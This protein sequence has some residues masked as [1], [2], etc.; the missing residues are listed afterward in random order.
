MQPILH[1]YKLRLTNLSQGNRSL[2]LVRLSARRD[3]D[4]TSLSF[5]NKE[6]AEQILEKILAGRD[7]KLIQKLS[8]RDE[9]VNLLDRRLNS[10]YRSVTS[11]YEESGTYDLY[12]GYPFVEGKFLDGSS[13]RCPVMLFPVKLIRNFQGSPRWRLE[14]QEEEEV[15]LNKTFFL[16]FEKF[17]QVRF[18]AEFW[19]AEIP[20]FK[21]LQEYLN[22]FYAFLKE[23][24]V[25]VNFNSDLFR[26]RLAP[27]TDQRKD[28]FDALPTG[29]LKFQPFAVIGIFPQSDSALLKDYDTLEAQ[30]EDFDLEKYLLPHAAAGNDG[31]Y[32]R[33]EHRY[34]VAPVDQSQEEAILKVKNGNSVVVHGPPG[35]GKSQ[36]ILNLV[37]DGMAN[38]KK[39]LVVSQKR[40]ALDVVYH[41]LAELGLD[42]FVSLVHDYGSDRSEIY[43]HIRK[44]IEDI[45]QF[46]EEDR[47][48]NITT[49]EHAFRLSSRKI[50]DHNRFFE[51]LYD[52]LVYPREFGLTIHDLYLSADPRGKLFPLEDLPGRFDYAGLQEFLVKVEGLTRY[53]DL[54]KP[55][56]PWRDRLPLHDAGFDK[57]QR[58]QQALDQL[59]NTIQSL[60]SEWEKL[61]HLNNNILVPGEN[62]EKIAE[63]RKW[64]QWLQ[65]PEVARDMA[66]IFSGAPGFRESGQKLRVF[67]EIFGKMGELVLL[68]DLSW[69]IFLDLREHFEVFEAKKDKLFKV[70]SKPFRKARW[71]IHEL[72]FQRKKEPSEENILA[73]KKE[74]QVY[75]RLMKHYH[76][77]E[78]L[79]FFNDL[80]LTGTHQERID[81][82]A[83]KKRNRERVKRV[84]KIKYFPKLKPQ[85]KN[86]T[87]DKKHWQKSMAQLESLHRFSIRLKD[88]IS[89]WRAHFSAGQIARM[90]AAIPDPGKIAEH[91]VDLNQYF[92]Q[93][94]EDMRALDGLFQQFS[95]HEKQVVD[96]LMPTLEQLKPGKEK[97]FLDRLKNHFFLYWMEQAERRDPELTEVTSRMF[98]E[99]Q[100]D[101]QAKLQ[102]R[103]EGVVNLIQRKLKQHIIDR[104]EYN[105][106][107]NPITYREILHQV[108][109]KR[110]IW[111]VRKLISSFWE[112]GLN[113]L[114]PVWMASP[115]SVAAIF[116]MVRDYFDLVIFDEAS[117]C[118]VER[119]IPVLL[120]GKA[121]VVA[122][123]DKQLPPFDLYSIKAET[124]EE[125]FYENEV[126]LEVESI[127][128]LAKNV[129]PEQ[130]LSWHYRSREEELINFSNYKFYEGR[131]KVVPP[132]RHDPVFLPP[133]EWV[134]VDG[135]WEQ[136]RN[137]AEAE[138]VVDLVE[139]WVFMEAPPTVGVV[140]FNYHQM[141]EIKDRMDQRV[142]A[143]V[144]A[145]ETAK[146][147]KWYAAIE[148]EDGEER[149]GVFVKNIENVQ[150]DERDV[151]IFSV[152][153][154][155]NKQGKL[156]SQFGSL[157][158]RGGENRLNVAVTRA[159]K[160]VVVVCSFM[161]EELQVADSK[162]PGPR[163]FKN[164][165]LYARSVAMGETGTELLMDS[166]REIPVKA[167]VGGAPGELAFRVAEALES[168][169]YH[170]ERNVGDTNYKLDLAIKKSPTDTEYLLGI[171]C[172]GNNYFSGKTPKEREVYR[173]GLLV[174]RGWKLYRLWARNYFL[175]PEKEIGKILNAIGDQE[176]NGDKK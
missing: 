42:R 99:K 80:P 111:P 174:D 105:R 60:H 27:F 5:V 100:A 159:K 78:A 167:S 71:F 20:R 56:Y 28:F 173:P 161:P 170:V 23:H 102:E 34:F 109:K 44:Q 155:K 169:G 11:I 61:A 67:E 154:A 175:D 176:R 115:E 140:T 103:Q 153:Y 2:K 147:K 143:W 168:R 65:D 75:L 72:L 130:K 131:L 62:E 112:K 83:R 164:Y 116:P 110:R 166:G 158:Q 8:A 146:V 73:L 55:E 79:A 149:Q 171:E 19:E 120:R 13:A 145:G 128:D 17:Q 90:T 97:V 25:E 40:A 6:S 172:E 137:V 70:L 86:G 88:Q 148:R 21:T 53:L 121:A 37:A 104:I 36:V 142:Q 126:A 3:I 43:A 31:T 91:L 151:I 49:W 118:Y 117:Q 9:S 135:L 119:A 7:V 157:S 30:P 134:S 123:D 10:I 41:R 139:K 101:Y 63:F 152:A 129:L 163:L 45:D 52:A 122:G 132:A 87:L 4:L 16:A 68:N 162:N 93:D 84:R 64:D 69:G 96:Q 12:L 58:F 94:F 66:A 18:S 76:E 29:T 57:K 26:F 22:W 95:P 127:L 59:V 81:W 160:K 38:G 150:G 39:V 33:E 107:K 1:Q 50:D 141:E 114:M 54:L 124:E 51:G 74:S 89:T 136:N 156:V 108:S 144:D 106:L 77:V 82:L 48:L 92:N 24:Q 133:I 15:Q 165:L 35:T 98:P 47:D 14:S 46:K 113:T 85:A 138:K 125:A 32:I